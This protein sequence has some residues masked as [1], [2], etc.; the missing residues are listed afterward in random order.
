MVHK[1]VV[2][3]DGGDL[4]G[5]VE[6]GIAEIDHGAS[7]SRRGVLILSLVES[8]CEGRLSMTLTRPPSF[9]SCVLGGA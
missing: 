9:E 1:G 7:F 2:C 6:R 5:L 4:T 8:H 3:G